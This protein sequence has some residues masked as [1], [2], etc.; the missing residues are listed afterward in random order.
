LPEGVATLLNSLFASTQNVKSPNG[1]HRSDVVP[2]GFHSRL[3]VRLDTLASD[4][5]KN[6]R[7]KLALEAQR[8]ALRY[9]PPQNLEALIPPLTTMAALLIANGQPRRGLRSPVPSIGTVKASASTSKPRG[10]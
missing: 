8:K 1:W 4:P 6:G 9:V 3:N 5:A 7:L 10:T 2:G